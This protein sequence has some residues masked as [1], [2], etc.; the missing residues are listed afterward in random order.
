MPQTPILHCAAYSLPELPLYLER[1][2]KIDETKEVASSGSRE[3][4]RAVKREC[5]C[6][7][8][9]WLIPFLLLLIPVGAAVYFWTKKNDLERRLNNLD[10]P[11]RRSRKT[12]RRQ[13]EPRYARLFKGDTDSDDSCEQ[14]IDSIRFSDESPY[15]PQ[16]SDDFHYIRSRSNPRSRSRDPSPSRQKPNSPK[17]SKNKEDKTQKPE[18][19]SKNDKI[20]E[21]A[22]A[23]LSRTMKYTNLKVVELQESI[24]CLDQQVKD[25][26]CEIEVLKEAFRLRASNAGMM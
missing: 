15:D 10:D 20:T 26:C 18:S 2:S 23:C 5:E 17:S 16:G 14:M 1:S 4:A 11:K 13:E 9:R 25:M 19:S 6:C 24:C 7:G 12:R 8:K 21:R 22:I 3:V